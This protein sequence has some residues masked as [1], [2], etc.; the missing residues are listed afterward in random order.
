MS[1]LSLLLASK[2]YKNI[3]LGISLAAP[4]GPVSVETIK[5]GLSHGFKRAFTVVLGAAVGDLVTMLIFYFLLSPFMTIPA[6]EVT[7]WGLG[8][9]ILMY[10]GITS[11]YQG[12]QNKELIK[13]F[14]PSQRNLFLLGFALA[15][16]NPISIAFWIGVA[17]LIFEDQAVDAS[18]IES[19]TANLSI[20]VGVVIWGLFLS[21]WLALGR[22]YLNN[23]ALRAVAVVSGLCLLGFGLYYLQKGLTTLN[24]VLF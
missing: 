17:G 14:A 23:S 1:F 22:K 9:L 24:L 20:F 3:V 8:A 5:Q 4:I 21:S 16:V 11:I 7:V 10:L 18:F 12:M 19:F 6:V 15:I 2:F 13:D